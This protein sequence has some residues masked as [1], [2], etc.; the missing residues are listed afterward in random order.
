[1]LPQRK[2]NTH[3]VIIVYVNGER[4]C[5][6]LHYTFQNYETVRTDSVNEIAFNS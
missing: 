1:M 2:L 6:G 3:N 5:S 4:K